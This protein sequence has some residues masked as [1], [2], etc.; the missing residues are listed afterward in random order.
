M[1][2]IVTRRPMS[3]S[4]PVPF[5]SRPKSAV[6][7]HWL[8]HGSDERRVI[9]NAALCGL[10][11]SASPSGPK[12]SARPMDGGPRGAGAGRGAFLAFGALV[13]LGAADALGAGAALVVLPALP[14]PS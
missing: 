11:P 1:L 5:L 12:A 9:A 7:Y 2:L 14:V 4:S 8:C 13:A 10:S 3:S 6:A